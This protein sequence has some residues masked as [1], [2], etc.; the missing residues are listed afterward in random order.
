MEVLGLLGE[1]LSNAA[2]ADRLFVSAKTV[3]HHV[4]AILGKL[5]VA[6]RGEAAALA[7]NEGWF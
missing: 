1:G 4:S 7:R 5:D 2:I 6:S 3:D